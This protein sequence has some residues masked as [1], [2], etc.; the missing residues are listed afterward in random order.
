MTAMT[1]TTELSKM[2][3]KLIKTDCLGRIRVSP[4]HRKKILDAFEA[5]S[6]SGQKF[7]E[8][9]GVKYQT[10]ASWVQ[11]RK[12]ERNE[13]SSEVAIAP[14]ALIGTLAEIELQPS[15]ESS[16]ISVEL[17]GGARL[18]LSTPEQTALAAAL[19]NKLTR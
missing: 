6:M 16:A 8:H 13:Y 7:A 10:F 17:P 4:E 2:K 19:I 14:S 9:S 5:S 3:G 12:R 18:T 11:K 15:E 1:T